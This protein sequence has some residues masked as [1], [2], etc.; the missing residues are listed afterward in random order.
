MHRWTVS[1][2]LSKDWHFERSLSLVS[3][4][5]AYL[6]RHMPHFLYG[7]QSL[8][9]IVDAGSYFHLI[10][11]YITTGVVQ[12]EYLFLT[13]IFYRRHCRLW[14]HVT[15]TSPAPTWLRRHALPRRCGRGP[16]VRTNIDSINISFYLWSWSA[17]SI[18]RYYGYSKVSN[19]Q[20]LWL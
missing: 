7:F 20:I 12:S 15:W 9:A 4:H 18:T 8:N 6:L 3:C 19:F 13:L 11:Y 5:R 16:L 17:Y 14:W 2:R 10:L 1:R